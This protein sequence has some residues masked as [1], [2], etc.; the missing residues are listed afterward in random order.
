MDHPN[1]PDLLNEKENQRIADL[2]SELEKI[3]EDFD[4]LKTEKA[5]KDDVIIQLQN[6]LKNKDDEIKKLKEDAATSGTTAT[7]QQTDS[8]AECE[9]AYKQ[10][11]RFRLSLVIYFIRLFLIG[12]K[13]FEAEAYKIDELF[14]LSY[15]DFAELVKMQQDDKNFPAKHKNNGL[16]V[17]TLHGPSF[18]EYLR[19]EYFPVTTLWPLDAAKQIGNNLKI[20]IT[21]LIFSFAAFH[22][23][24]CLQQFMDIRTFYAWDFQRGKLTPCSI[25]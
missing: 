23:T 21:S 14:F 20:Y 3:K 25:S 17:S 15:A 19:D 18:L 11:I 8:F 1:I 24:P 16:L 4:R 5:E 9:S 12:K 22:S 13:D 7:P 2:T 6:D 10:F